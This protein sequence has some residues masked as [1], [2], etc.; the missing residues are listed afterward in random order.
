VPT[1][2]TWELIQADPSLS[3]FEEAVITAGLESSIGGTVLAPNDSAVSAMP[4]SAAILI[5]PT[6][7]AEFVLSHMVSGQLDS[8]AI[9]ASPT[10]STQGGDTLTIDGT[11]QT[12]AGPDGTASI[13]SPDNLGTDGFL[14][15]INAVLDVPPP[16]VAPTTEAPTTTADSTTTTV[17]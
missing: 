15:V 16:P 2:T 11:L 9:F 13:V 8:A 12:I 6:A 1:Q 10:L 5:D 14:H 7:A 4:D 17:I 3:L